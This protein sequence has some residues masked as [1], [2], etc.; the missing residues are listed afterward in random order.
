MGGSKPAQRAQRG[1]L[2]LVRGMC[3]RHCEPAPAMGGCRVARRH[4]GRGVAQGAAAGPR[5][6]RGAPAARY[7]GLFDV[8]D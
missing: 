5:R 7:P 3:C 2:L 4:P 6:A 1:G 8:P